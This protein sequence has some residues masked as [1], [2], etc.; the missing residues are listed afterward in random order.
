MW[1]IKCNVYH[2][3]QEVCWTIR[4]RRIKGCWTAHAKQKCEMQFWN[5]LERMWERKPV[6]VSFCTLSS[7]FKQKMSQEDPLCSAGTLRTT[8]RPDVGQWKLSVMSICAWGIF[9]LLLLALAYWFCPWLHIEI[10]DH[11]KLHPS[12]RSDMHLSK[13]QGKIK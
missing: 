11:W 2:F 6:W 3:T 9:C 13:Q 10:C 1:K 7:S 4:R 8:Y 5:T 12:H